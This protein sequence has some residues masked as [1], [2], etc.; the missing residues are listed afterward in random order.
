MNILIKNGI[1]SMYYFNDNKSNRMKELERKINVLYNF[2]IPHET[3]YSNY[4]L[5]KSLVNN[6][7]NYKI[8]KIIYTLNS[9]CI[10]SLKIIYKNRNNNNLITV[11]NDDC[12]NENEKKYIIIFPDSL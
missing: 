12:L 10:Q 2:G 4:E 7:Y 3:I 9:N 6:I 11:E 1:K 5:P 8:S